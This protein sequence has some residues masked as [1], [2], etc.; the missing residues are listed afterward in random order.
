MF[1]DKSIIKHHTLNCLSTCE[2]LFIA[3]LLVCYFA[4]GILIGMYI[5][6]K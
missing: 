3:G 6:E 1:Q 5:S 2:K 4:K